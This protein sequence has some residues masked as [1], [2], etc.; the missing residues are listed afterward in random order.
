MAAST[1]SVHHG[2]YDDE[3]YT[4]YPVVII[5]AGSSGTTIPT[6]FWKRIDRTLTSTGIAAGC[7]IKSAL[8]FDQFAIFERQGGPGGMPS[9]PKSNS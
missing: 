8:G 4:Y 1:I 6:S 5:G 7:R 2:G 9:I 3:P